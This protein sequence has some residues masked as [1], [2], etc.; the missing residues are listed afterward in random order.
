LAI[1]RISFTQR[2]PKVFTRFVYTKY[3]LSCS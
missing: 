1:E 2:E 3:W